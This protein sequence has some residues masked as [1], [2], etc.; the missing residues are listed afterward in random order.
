MK[1]SK[2]MKR[3]DYEGL[4]KHGIP[5]TRPAI[6]IGELP[7]EDVSAALTSATREIESLLGVQALRRISYGT[8]VFVAFGLTRPQAKNHKEA[9]LMLT[10]GES[11]SLDL[12]Q[13]YDNGRREG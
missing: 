12:C 8:P 11:L 6:T 13:E 4:D 3:P 9:R 2:Q 1:V 5:Y 7:H 10:K